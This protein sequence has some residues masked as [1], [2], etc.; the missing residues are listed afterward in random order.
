MHSLETVEY[1]ALMM[2]HNYQSSFWGYFGSFYVDDE[3]DKP[4]ECLR[5]KYKEVLLVGVHTYWQC[6]QCDHNINFKDI[7][8]NDTIVSRVSMHKLPWE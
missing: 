7:E 4:R 1:I 8:Q 5:H 3:N 6:V 2:K